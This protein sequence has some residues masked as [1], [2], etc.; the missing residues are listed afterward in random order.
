MG[1]ML[2]IPVVL[3]AALL[4]ALIVVLALFRRTEIIRS[5]DVPPPPKIIPGEVINPDTAFF[6]EK[7]LAVA[8]AGEERPDFHA[9]R[10][11]INGVR[12]GPDGLPE[13]MEPRPR[14]M[15]E[16]IRGDGE[17]TGYG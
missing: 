7:D 11:D 1:D 14:T 16:R 13:Y 12:V 2:W 5:P 4:V 9:T 8:E 6:D 3:L 17:A 10:I 15:W